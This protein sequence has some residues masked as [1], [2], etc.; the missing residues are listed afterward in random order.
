MYIA[1]NSSKI[2]MEEAFTK[3][4]IKKIIEKLLINSNNDILLTFKI[5]S[6]SFGKCD[7]CHKFVA[8]LKCRK[9][10]FEKQNICIACCNKHNNKYHLNSMSWFTY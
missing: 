10:Y 9:I 8:I 6:Y 1:H 5:L 7:L 2:V 4:Q 3:Y